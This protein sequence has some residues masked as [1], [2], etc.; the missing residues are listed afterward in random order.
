VYAG[1]IYLF[2]AY[3]RMRHYVM[4]QIRLNIQVMSVF[5][6]IYVRMYVCIIM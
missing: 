3:I 6:Y 2:P 5:V 4:D 1:Y